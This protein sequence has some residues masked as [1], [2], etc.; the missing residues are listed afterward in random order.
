MLAKRVRTT[1]INFNNITPTTSQKTMKIIKIMTGYHKDQEVNFVET[2]TPRIY[3]RT[4]DN[5]QGSFRGSIQVSHK[6][7]V[8]YNDRELE[9]KR[10]FK[11]KKQCVEFLK[12]TWEAELYLSWLNDFISTERFAEHYNLKPARALEIIEQ[13]RAN[14]HG[15]KSIQTN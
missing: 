9:R 2:S 11:T 4:A 8:T 14:H 7:L 13:G 1:S 10:F 6:W 3:K 15:I 5:V 12:N